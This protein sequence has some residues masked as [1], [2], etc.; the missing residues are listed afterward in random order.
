MH[1]QNAALHS[2]RHI[3]NGSHCEWLSL[4]NVLNGSGFFRVTC[5]TK[6][7]FCFL[8]L[9]MLES[10]REDVEAK[11]EANVTLACMAQTS[12]EAH[13]VPDVLAVLKEVT[14]KTQPLAASRA[15]CRF[16]V[17]RLSAVLS[18]IGGGV[19]VL[20]RKGDDTGVHPSDG[21]LQPLH[22]AR[23]PRALADP[24]TCAH[25]AVRRANRGNRWNLKM[26][27]WCHVRLIFPDGLCE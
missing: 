23:G 27:P 6:L 20:A 13:N 11:H 25:V 19:S 14:V 8:Q 10:E 4:S 26:A 21:V 17:Q 16:P 9:C 2:S 18:L 22:A 5:D 12:L 1:W 3:Q 7:I 15:L 24:G